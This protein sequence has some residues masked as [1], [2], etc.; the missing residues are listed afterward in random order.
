MSINPPSTTQRGLSLIEL[1][2]FIVVV[3]VGVAGLVSVI[4]PMVRGS[5]DPM[6]T[7]QLTAIAEALLNE[8]MQKPF[9][10][11]DPG[12]AKA[13]TA[14]SYADCATP[15]NKNGAPLIG[16]T[17]SSETRRTFN[18]VADY[19]AFSKV[20]IDDLTGNHTMTGYTASVN[21]ERAGTAFGLSDND[22]ALQVTVTVTRGS[23][24]FSLTGY[25]L[26]YAPRT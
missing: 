14:Q 18:N 17:P 10:W 3:S 25:R 6:V 26:R 9:T 12:D 5:A 7:K 19:G 13:T 8:V 1:I 21:V 23:E 4:S 22:A 24:S 15:Q 11:C 16:P 20:D 2:M